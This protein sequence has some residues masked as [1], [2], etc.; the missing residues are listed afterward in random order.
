MTRTDPAQ[1]LVD[2]AQRAQRAPSILNTQPWRWRVGAAVL[3]LFADLDRQ[4]RSIDPEGRLLMLSC[5]AALHH[6]RA[7][8]AAT[9]HDV[10]VDR[11][12]DPAVPDLLASLRLTSNHEPPYRDVEALRNMRRRHTDRRPFVATVAVP[13]EAIS[14]MKQAAQSED[15]WLHQIPPQQLPVLAAAAEKAAAAE[16]RMEDYQDDLDR[17]TRRPRTSGEGVPRETVAAQTP[18]LV[19]I[20]DFTPGRE[21]LLDPGFGDDRFAEFLI[22]AT[23]TDTPQH[24]LRAGEATSAAWLAATSAG[25]VV[26]VLSDVI[27]IGDA[28]ALLRRL[29]DPPAYPQLV[30]RVG[31]NMQPQPPPESPRRP[32]SEVID[33]E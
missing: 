11:F 10:A 15:A 21:T 22:L 26:S 23:A 6:A 2:A 18:R 4:I 19:R 9:G 14:S 31:V 3:H 29:L 33:Y 16:A 30:F 8:L 1:V 32:A 12:P 7:A 17:W 24:W 20:R 13:T 25:L 28:R 5:G 27:E